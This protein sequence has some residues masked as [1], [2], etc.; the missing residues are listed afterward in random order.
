MKKIT[1]TLLIICSIFT[2]GFFPL[3]PDRAEITGPENG[4]V[5]LPHMRR[6]G[7]I[8]I[9]R[10]RISLLGA[11]N[12]DL[13]LTLNGEVTETTAS[14]F[15]VA[16][17]DLEEGDNL[18]T[19]RNGDATVELTVIRNISEPRDPDPIIEYAEP[20]Y[21][22][23]P[24]DNIS[25]FYD[26]DD[27][28][29]MGTPLA[30]GTVFKIVAG[31]NEFYRLQDGSYVFKTNIVGVP[32]PEVSNL[33]RV[34]IQDNRVTSTV[35][36]FD[37]EVSSATRPF[38]DDKQAVGYF[39]NIVEPQDD[40]IGK[41]MSFNYAPNCLTE[42]TVIID[43][44][45]GGY[46]PGALGPLGIYGPMEKDLNLYVARK[47]VEYLESHG[48]NVVFMR[49]DDEDYRIL[50]RI[51]YIY[52]MSM[53]REF[54]HV[55]VSVH[56]NATHMHNDFSTVS[57]AKMYYTLDQSEDA[58]NIILQHIAEQTRQD[59]IP[60]IKRNFAMAR[61]TPGASMLFEMGYMCNPEDYELLIDIDY[62]DLMA[63]SLGEG[64]VKYLM[65]FIEDEQEPEEIPVVL[66]VTTAP[67][68]T[69]P[70]ETT[71]EHNPECDCGGHARHKHSDPIAIS[72]AVITAFIL[73]LTIYTKIKNRRKNNERHEKDQDSLHIRPGDGE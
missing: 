69:E 22:T 56:A 39:V 72:L 57:G 70:P 12:P 23:T 14:G 4:Y 40:L 10:P 27:D 11:S 25:R 29:K 61:Y 62:L 20:M 43:A 17:V 35:Y 33:Y 54:A 73:V 60:I 66:P 7:T 63:T 48:I 49:D 50:D 16:Y 71:P 67:I 1:A 45:H 19:F 53:Q 8:T 65:T 28:R 58:A 38:A 41:T 21:G 52:Q 13:P 44:G 36:D 3:P 47:T 26:R 34:E 18:F 30:K 64:I 32:R 5:I 2:L 15:F 42:A 55:L 46:D 51:D 37:G 31:N 9:S 59:F 68:T 24:Y 6:D